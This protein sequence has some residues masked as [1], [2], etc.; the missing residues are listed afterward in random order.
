M[1]RTADEVLYA[2]FDR[3][4][5]MR[6]HGLDEEARGKSDEREAC[7][8]DGHLL[9]NERHHGRGRG[10]D[11]IGSDSNRFGLVVDTCAIVLEMKLLYL[12]RYGTSG[13]T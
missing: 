9:I 5:H 3:S 6:N 4:S 7:V 12:V 13:T 10:L 11:L 8:V 2:C 1:A